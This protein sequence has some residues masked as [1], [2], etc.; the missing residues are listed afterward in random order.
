MRDAAFYFMGGNLHNVG[1]LLFRNVIKIAMK[2]NQKMSR[3]LA[4]V[5]VAFSE[6]CERSD[7][8]LKDGIFVE[9]VM[10]VT[11]FENSL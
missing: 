1:L 10:C 8:R 2:C 11:I 7:D 4:C 9:T 5:I 3:D 6:C